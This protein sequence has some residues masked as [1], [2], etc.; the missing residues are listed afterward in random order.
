MLVSNLAKFGS[1][2][3]TQALVCT[4]TNSVLS[5]SGDNEDD[6]AL[7][8]LK[9]QFIQNAFAILPCKKVAMVDKMT[10]SG[11]WAIGT[12]HA[13]QKCVSGYEGRY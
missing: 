9:A 13:P 8:E 2:E 4:S 1:V 6:L 10:A 5:R 7:N 12:Q 3:C 11:D